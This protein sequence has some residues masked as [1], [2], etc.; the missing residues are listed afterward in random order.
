MI[1]LPAH[2]RAT[3]FNRINKACLSSRPGW[4]NTPEW[5]SSTFLSYTAKEQKAKYLIGEKICMNF[6]Q[7][8]LTG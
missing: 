7:E 6:K 5:Q 4:T 3:P 1:L 2:N 8:C